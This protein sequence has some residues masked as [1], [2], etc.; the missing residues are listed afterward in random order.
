M[1]GA[2]SAQQKTISIGTGGTGGVL[3][4]VRRRDSRGDRRFDCR[5]CRRPPKSAAASVD[6]L[7]LISGSG[8]VDSAFTLRRH[9]LD[10]AV[11]GTGVR[12]RAPARWKARVARGPLSEL[13]PRGDDRL[14]GDR[15]AGRSAGGS[16]RVDRFARQRLRK[17]SRFACS[18]P[19]GL[20]LGSGTSPSP[21]WQ[22]LSVNA[23]RTR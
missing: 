15:P 12:S 16:R 14:H 8:K 19:S 13:H 20:D 18:A 21:C 11:Q 23:R 5:A 3:L 2:A 6:N 9:E 17:R 22:A 4:S 7:K 1:F 10:S